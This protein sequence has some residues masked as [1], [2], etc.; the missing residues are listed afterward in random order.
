MISSLQASSDTAL[1]KRPLSG[2]PVGSGSRLRA[3]WLRASWLLWAPGAAALFVL[4]GAF[5][6][7][8]HG[9]D[10][11]L[12]VTIALSAAVAAAPLA[13]W[14]ALAFAGLTVAGQSLGVVPPPFVSGVWAYVAIPLLLFVTTLT[15]LKRSART[16]TA[17][18]PA[19][20]NLRKAA[21]LL[22]APPMST[23]LAGVV[24]SALIA[25]ACV[26][27]VTWMNNVLPSAFGFGRLRLAVYATFLF[28]S[29]VCLCL[30][31]WGAALIVHRAGTSEAAHQEAEATVQAQA[32]TLAL[33]NERE[34][35][36]REL[37]DILAHSLTV[38]AAQAD[39]V[40]YI[41]ATEPETAQESA[42]VIA[43]VART[44]LRDV[45]HLLE[46]GPDQDG[47]A[48]GLE[49]LPELLERFRGSE[50]PVRLEQD[51]VV[52]SPA[53]Q[54]AVYRVVQESLTNAFRHGQRAQGAHVRISKHHDGGVELEVVSVLDPGREPKSLGER[55]GLGI[56]G[57]RQRAEAL[58]GSLHAGP[59]A[60]HFTVTAVL[61]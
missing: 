6:V 60:S 15:Q 51:A 35:I 13:P 50:M 34:R 14:T 52:L 45:R 24:L 23:A 47:P 44:A 4:I 25:V 21:A 17:G 38:I 33:Q 20:S 41:A 37:H 48:P 8:G 1:R 5:P 16:T 27:D 55:R 19:P 40:R 26:G 59:A 31:A 49:D 28:L 58:G 30:A 39:G 53:Q 42:G 7:E 32:V 2:T 57:M 54:L 29:A 61:P 9:F 10:R 22:S 43:S 11:S 36:S 46:S 18:R 12:S 56:A 3:P